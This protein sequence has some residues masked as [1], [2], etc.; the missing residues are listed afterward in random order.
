MV[1]HQGA[2]HETQQRQLRLLP[3]YRVDA[4]G[5][6]ALKR[7][8]E[9]LER[10]LGITRAGFAAVFAAVVCWVLAEI[11]AGWLSVAIGAKREAGWALAVAITVYLAVVHL[12]LFWPNFP[13]WYNVA[14]AL[15]AAPAVLIGGMLAR[16]FAR[17]KMPAAVG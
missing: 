5:P 1:T 7:R 8:F 13:W 4:L 17:A 16:G 14:V 9:E 6:S 3:A 12:L 11:I 2:V 10:K 15:F